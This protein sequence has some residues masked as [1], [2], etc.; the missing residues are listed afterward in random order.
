MKLRVLKGF[1]LV[2]LVVAVAVAG[3]LVGIA[4]PLYQG[5]V[6]KTQVG[7]VM[8]EV[9]HFRTIVE[10]CIT[11]GRL[12]VG[13]QCQLGLYS[14]DLVDSFVAT[15]NSSPATLRAEFGGHAATQLHGFHLVWL[16]AGSGEWSCRSN[17]DVSYLPSECD[18]E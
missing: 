6:V 1:S 9:G 12:E 3:L 18:S 11:A 10:D 4:I 15:L 14:S 13:E 16:R 17:I 5:Y 2:E 8:H 7:R